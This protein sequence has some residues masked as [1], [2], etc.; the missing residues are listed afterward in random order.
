[1]PDGLVYL[2]NSTN[3]ESAGWYAPGV[4]R[5]LLKSADWQAVDPDAPADAGAQPIG[6]RRAPESSPAPTPD[7]DTP[8]TA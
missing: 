4:A 6:K 2:T 3:P 8:P 7:S 1:M 5:V